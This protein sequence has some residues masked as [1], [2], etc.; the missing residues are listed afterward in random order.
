MRT[1]VE[2]SQGKYGFLLWVHIEKSY[3]AGKIPE[4]ISREK[5]LEKE[6]LTSRLIDR[7]IRPLF[8][9]GFKNRVQVICTCCLPE[10]DT[11]P[12]IAAMI[13]TLAALSISGIPFN[14][15]VEQQGA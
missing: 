13:G 11:D 6:T 1:V 14:A 7:P 4:D 5:D 9:D 10:K 15:P 2:K 12:D 3:S 8:P